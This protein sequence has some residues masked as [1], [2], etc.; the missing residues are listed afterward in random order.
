[1][2]PPAFAARLKSCPFK[3]RVLALSKLCVFRGSLSVGIE[4]VEFLA[5]FEPDGFAWRDADLGAS[6]WITA[7][8]RL[9]GADAENAKTPQFDAVARG[10]SLLQTLKD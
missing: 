5:R 10:K 1:M 7:N 4:G 2:I 9:A 6:A 8:A 3:A